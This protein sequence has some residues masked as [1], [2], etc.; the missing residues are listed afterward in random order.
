[1]DATC[2]GMDFHLWNADT[3]TELMFFTPSEG[4]SLCV[5]NYEFSISADPFGCIADVKSALIDLTGPITISNKE[6][7]M[8]F[9]V[10][11]D[12]RKAGTVYPPYE[13]YQGNIHGRDWKV[14]DYTIKAQFYS[15]LNLKGNLV[16][17]NVVN[18]S[19]KDCGRRELKDDS[20]GHVRHGN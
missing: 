13:Q 8:P 6:N 7:Q 16:D 19:V 10:F 12:D 1:V 3:S 5:Q 14:G 15:E 4:T 17:T 2:N 11:R 20:E 18:F 9:T